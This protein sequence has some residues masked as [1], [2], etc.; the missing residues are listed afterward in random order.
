[1]YIYGKNGFVEIFK[2]LVR[3]ENKSKNNFVG[4]RIM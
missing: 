4:L 3:Y 2:N 1:M